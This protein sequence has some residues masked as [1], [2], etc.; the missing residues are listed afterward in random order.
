MELMLWRWSTSAQIASALMIAVFFVVLARSMR[1]AELQPWVNA[2]LANLGALAVTTIYW[3]FQPENEL[4]FAAIRFCYFFGKTMFVALLAVGAWRVIRPRLGVGHE[5]ALVLWVT[6][7]AFVAALATKTIDQLGVTQAT[8]M[9]L[10]L[11]A[12]TMILVISRAPGAG[13]L[14]VGCGLRAV[15]GFVEA[16]GYGSRL[17]TLPWVPKDAV[18]QFLSMHSTFDTGAEWMIALGCV[19]VVN[20]TIQQELT[21]ANTDLLQAKNALQDLV[22][23][24]SLTGLLNR[25]AIPAVMRESYDVG[26]TV[27]FFD[28]ND[29]KEINDSYGHQV[30]DDCLKRFAQVL[31]SSF[32]PS[33]RVIRYAGDEFVV[34]AVGAEPTQVVDRL[35]VMRERFKTERVHGHQLAFSAGYAYLARHGDSEAA[36][37]AADEAMYRDKAT[38]PSGLG[39]RKVAAAG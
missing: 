39:R 32:R 8:T 36:M 21:R 19:L 30:G 22:D 14:A 35:D 26:A 5:R 37:K 24:D 2:W 33:D 10:V 9:T 7:F 31:Q 13:W 17:V 29:F 12:A 11:G 16:L 27:I 34:V 38:K 1:R 18:G 15:F 3:L 6:G 25:R 4:A 28:L 23:N 20:R